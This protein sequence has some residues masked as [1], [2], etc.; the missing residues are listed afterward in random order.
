MNEVRRK[1][2]GKIPGPDTGIE[3]RKSICTICDPG[4]ECGLNLYVKDGK[5]IKVEGAP[6]MPHSHGSLC[7][8]GAATRQYVYNRERVLTPLRRVGERGEGAFEEI[9]WDEALDEIA[10]KLN[11]I[12]AQYGPESVVFFA[13]YPKYFRPFLQ[14]LALDFGSPNYCCESST[15]NTAI[16]MAQQLTYGAGAAAD[17]SASE[18]V[19]FWTRNFSHSSTL[20]M[21]RVID[22]QNAGMKMIVVDPRVTYMAMH[23]DIHLQIRPGTD[24]ALALALANV[25]IEEG[26]YDQE[27]V[28][29]WTE[30][31]DE[32]AAYVAQM[33]PEKAAGICAVDAEL[34]YAAARL[35]A[36]SKPASIMTSAAAVVHHTNGVQN[37][38]AVFCLIGL[39]GNLDV[40][41]GNMI[42]PGSIAHVP[43]GFPTREGA[44][45]GTE[46]LAQ[47][48]PR[49]GAQRFPV[50]NR[51]T[52]M[53]Q[54]CDIPRQIATGDP[55]PLKAAVCLGLNYRMWPDS[56][57]FI[58]RLCELEFIVDADPFLTDSAKYADIVLPVCTSVERSEVRCW[59]MGY[60]ICTQPAI[61]P[62]GQARPDVDIIAALCAKLGLGDE[63]L[64]SGFDACMDWMLEPSGMTV[65]QL[66][67]HESGM[68]YPDKK[69]PRQRKYLEGGFN[70]PSGKF[71]FASRVM[72]EFDGEGLEA[73]PVY[74]ESAMS[75][76]ST[77]DVATGYPLVLVV[78]SRLPMFQHSRMFRVP[79]VR[80]FAKDP[81]ADLN[82]RTAAAYG[83][84]DGQWVEISTPH[85]SVRMRAHL[86]EMIREGD[87]HIF[88]DWPQA[89]GNSLLAGD[90][91][92]PVSGFPGYR[93]SLCKIVPA[94]EEEKGE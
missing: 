33:T 2:R 4:T 1:L 16:V 85:A 90:Y 61:E 8:K 12:K 37:Y 25:I 54:A 31:F 19:I 39:T 81:I 86:T 9:S 45:P 66:R 82:P 70:T 29:E 71:E 24:G 56:E 60:V 57:N 22:R 6:E 53:A 89:N 78:G 17:L 91:L 30:G 67:E 94:I 36:T 63:L 13:G 3:I 42:N 84:E 49:I 65:A 83:V 59:P 92:D 40:A 11:D 88:H 80:Q 41:G 58:K 77:P 68:W 35:Y 74:H 5:I 27:F 15:C 18:C 69:P 7:A 32:Y 10:A 50:W 51:L 55:Y 62:V 48:P 75:P 93:S 72:S 38:R 76:V 21:K 64:E 46:R 43:G 23:A 20:D 14:R 73:L 34:I 26:L 52:D 47:L 79:W 28:R 87:V 44:F